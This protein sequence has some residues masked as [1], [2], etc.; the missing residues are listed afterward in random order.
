M[1]SIPTR[2]AAVAAVAAV[3]AA[4]ACSS[5]TVGE[6]VIPSPAVGTYVLQTV[7]G[8]ALPASV[9]TGSRVV[10]FVA[11]TLHL[12]LGGTF[13]ETVVKQNAPPGQTATTSTTAQVNGAW[14]D[15]GSAISVS[16]GGTGSFSGGNTLT[17]AATLTDS[18]TQSTAAITRVFQK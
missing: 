16:P 17:L 12:L 14:S 18:A 10:T 6:A 15:N 9:S 7:N 1:R 13:T 3:T 5:D 4:A 8:S 2:L 11:D